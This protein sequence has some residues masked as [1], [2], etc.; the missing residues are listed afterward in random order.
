MQLPV[1]RH[2]F[3]ARDNQAL[4]PAS[5]RRRCAGDEPTRYMALFI[6]SCTH[7]RTGK[8]Y[9]MVEWPSRHLLRLPGGTAPGVFL[10]YDIVMSL[11]GPAYVFTPPPG[12]QGLEPMY[13]F[14]PPALAFSPMPYHNGAETTQNLV[15]KFG[16]ICSLAGTLRK[17]LVAS[18]CSKVLPL[19]YFFK[20][21]FDMACRFV[22]ILRYFHGST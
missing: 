15:F 9:G 18:K 21:K 10:Q 12:C 8:C 17:L 22:F 5:L 7:T 11:P 3:A 4:Q 2:H 6:A 19:P 16:Y 13:T 20:L 1:A 14:T